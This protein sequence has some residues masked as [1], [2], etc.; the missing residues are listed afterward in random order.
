MYNVYSKAEYF[1]LKALPGIYPGRCRRGMV[2]AIVL[3]SVLWAGYSVAQPLSYIYIQGDKNTPFY[4]KMDGQMQPRYGKNH[5]IISSLRAGQV[6]IEILFQQNEFPAEKFT[7]DVPENGSKGFLLD[8]H[9]S[10]FVLYDLRNKNFIKPV[11][12][13]VK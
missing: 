11:S 13:E 4:V 6:S 12:G 7:I 8:K 3:L 9:D 2:G 10:G 1:F 5:C